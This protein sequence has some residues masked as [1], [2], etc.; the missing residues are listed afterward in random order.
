MKFCWWEKEKR[1]TVSDVATILVKCPLKRVSGRLNGK[2]Q[3]DQD[4][5]GTRQK[6]HKPSHEAEKVKSEQNFGRT[7]KHNTGQSYISE[8]N[9]PHKHTRRQPRT[10]TH[11]TTTRN[12]VQSKSKIK[13]L[14]TTT[15]QHNNQSRTPHIT[16]VQHALPPT[17]QLHY[18]QQL[19]WEWMLPTG[20]DMTHTI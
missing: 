11:H 9:T 15:P 6:Q 8:S 3:G 10:T 14:T 7:N 19:L 13:P 5:S 4:S 17:P 18:R 12:P 16:S 1:D 2:T 20:K